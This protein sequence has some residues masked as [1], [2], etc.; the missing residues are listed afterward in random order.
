[1]EAVIARIFEADPEVAREY[2]D[3]N[4]NN[5][6]DF[7]GNGRIEEIEIIRARRTGNV[8][9]EEREA[10]AR[11]FSGGNTYRRSARS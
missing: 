11:V 4:K 1:M 6:I 2:I 9:T 8:I 3:R 10:A 5:R 7:N